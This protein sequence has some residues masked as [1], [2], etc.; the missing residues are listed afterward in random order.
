MISVDQLR[1]EIGSPTADV[2]EAAA[3]TDGE[4]Q[5]LID[6]KT[7]ILDRIT[8]QR[9]EKRVLQNTP[10]SA[11]H[12]FE[13]EQI[14]LSP[15]GDVAQGSIT[16]NHYPL[17]YAPATD[18]SGWFSYDSNL[19]TE[20]IGFFD[21]RRFKFIGKD[22]I[23]I[24]PDT[25]SIT[26]RLPEKDK[27]QKTVAADVIEKVNRKIKEEATQMVQQKA[28]VGEDLERSDLDQ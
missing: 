11:T 5:N 17:T 22:V 9:M 20:S 19:E 3:V 8:K 23:V 16:T 25:S 14:S 15:N 27:A 28:Q 1:S 6:R 13:E 2:R 21:R 18:G 10:P 12:V 7:K 4:L 24:P 26:L